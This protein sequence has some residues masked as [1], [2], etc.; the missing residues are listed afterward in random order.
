MFFIENGGK[1]TFQERKVADSRSLLRQ[2]RIVAV[3]GREELFD[4]PVTPYI[5]P[6][7]K[8][9]VALKGDI[10]FR[11]FQVRAHIG[12]PSQGHRAVPFRTD[13]GFFRIIQAPHKVFFIIIRL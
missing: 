4:F 7:G 12:N 8:A 3:P 6:D 13:N 10:T 11:L 9:F 1:F 2:L 5:F